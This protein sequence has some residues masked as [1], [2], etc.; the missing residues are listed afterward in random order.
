MSRRGTTNRNDRGS[1]QD[2]A[3]RRAWLLETFGDGVS[4]PCFSCLVPLDD[5][6]ITVDRII[7]GCRGGRYVRGNIRPACAGCNSSLG[8]ALRAVPA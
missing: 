3:R 5:S 1:S 6:T 7:P 2:R 4:A 8:G